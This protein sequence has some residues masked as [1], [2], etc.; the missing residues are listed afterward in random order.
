MMAEESKDVSVREK[1][2]LEQGPE[3]TMP[4]RYFV[5]DTD[6][7]ET[8][9]A[10]TVVMDMPGVSRDR[11]SIDL[12]QGVLTIEGGIDTE[13]YRDLRPVYTEYNLGNFSR[14]F[15]LS[16]EIDDSS[17]TAQI[18]NGVLTVR[19]PKAESKKPRRIEVS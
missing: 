12:D 1:K 19:L 17:I 7:L 10:L 18:S 16:E 9:D 2:E 6:I 4:G 8:E 13:A 15:S 11:V 5:P 3:K 14:R